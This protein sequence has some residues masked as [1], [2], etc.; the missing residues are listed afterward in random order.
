MSALATRRGV[1]MVFAAAPLAAAVPASA[2]TT[3]PFA[4]AVAHWRAETAAAEHYRRAV[5][6]PAYEVWRAAKDAQDEL[7]AA[8]PHVRTTSSYANMGGG[9]STMTTECD[10]NVSLAR[11][12]L[13]DAKPATSQDDEDYLATLREVAGAADDREAEIAR[14]KLAHPLPPKPDEGDEFYERVWDALQAA[15][16]EPVRDARELA[17]KIAIMQGEDLFEHGASRDAFL[18]DVARLTGA[19]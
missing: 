9:R 3:S 16:A 18:R 4:R 6:G 1:L 8:V 11:R 13:A 14:I 5:F 15:I 2:A 19:A 17:E 12:V 10:W 7:I